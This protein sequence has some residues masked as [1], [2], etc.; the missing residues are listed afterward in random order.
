MRYVGLS[1]G[2]GANREAEH[3]LHTLGLPAGVEACTHLARV[4][5]PHV[6]VSLALPPAVEVEL[7]E[8][9]PE[10]RAPAEEAAA[11]HGAQRGG[12]AVLFAGVE[13]LVGTVT[14]AELLAGSAISRV[15]VLG[16]AAP[17]PGTEIVTR[18]FVRP[19]WMDG[20]LT[21]TATAAPRGR[22]APFEFPNPTPCCGGAH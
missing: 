16:G 15:K 20:E 13:R 21:L 6:A 5:Y 4:P 12:R 2:H 18:D 22:L 9:P 3:W 19:E 17:D 11:V 7:P 10:L 1:L 8:V 14:V